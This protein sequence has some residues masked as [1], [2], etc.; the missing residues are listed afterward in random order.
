MSLQDYESQALYKV[1]LGTSNFYGS[2][3]SDLTAGILLCMIDENGDSILQRIPSNLRPDDSKE[4]EDQIIQFQRG[5][6]DEFTFKGPKLEKIEA[7][8][9]SLESG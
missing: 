4:M 5:S 8:W 6:V 9:I 3:L 7:L 2:G 1:K